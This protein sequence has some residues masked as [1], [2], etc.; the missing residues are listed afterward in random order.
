MITPETWRGGVGV[1]PWG[2]EIG[3]HGK[4]KRNVRSLLDIRK[5]LRF[6]TFMSHYRS[7]EH[8]GRGT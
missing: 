7:V 5:W 8:P 3:T 1:S 4:E 2:G 6:C